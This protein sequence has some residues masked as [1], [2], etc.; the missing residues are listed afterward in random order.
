MT[1]AE[2]GRRFRA[3]REARGLTQTDV[4]AA[5]GVPQPRI[6]EYES[7]ARVPPTLRL[8]EIIERV[9]LDPKILFPEFFRHGKTSS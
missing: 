3:A 7:G 9:A 2:F 6:A 1:R 8:V 4:A 5:I